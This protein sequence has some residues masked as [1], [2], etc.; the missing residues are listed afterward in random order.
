MRAQLLYLASVFAFCSET[1]KLKISQ[2]KHNF[3]EFSKL[4]Q[5]QIQI[6]VLRLLIVAVFVV[7]VFFVETF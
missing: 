4:K 2:T 1:E 7:V 5:K 6:F 3:S